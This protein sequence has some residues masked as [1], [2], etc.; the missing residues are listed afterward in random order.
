MVVNLADMYSHEQLV[1]CM[2]VHVGPTPYSL[3]TR[4]GNLYR[5]LN[6]FV[7]MCAFYATI[8][9]LSRRRCFPNLCCEPGSGRP[10][11]LLV[12]SSSCLVS[13]SF[14]SEFEWKVNDRVNLSVATRLRDHYRKAPVL[15][16]SRV[17]KPPAPISETNP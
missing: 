2:V 6:C 17:D 8:R 10:P 14:F 16:T 13:W 5:Q 12:N 11:L 7:S 9:D 1:L 15:L 4:V 3:Q